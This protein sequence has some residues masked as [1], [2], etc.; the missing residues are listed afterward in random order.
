MCQIIEQLRWP[1]FSCIFH[2]LVICIC[3]RVYNCLWF[4][5]A[6]KKKLYMVC[7][8]NCLSILRNTLVKSATFFYWSRSLRLKAKPNPK[9]VQTRRKWRL[10][11]LQ[12]L[13]QLIKKWDINYLL[14]LLIYFWF[15]VLTRPL[16]C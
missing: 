11:S 6:K 8:L 1:T 3:F 5:L 14:I 7:L 12:D 16:D 10:F 2:R 13:Q 15:G 4:G 9:G